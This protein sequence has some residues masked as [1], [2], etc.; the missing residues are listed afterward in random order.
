[1][2]RG[3]YPLE[4][5]GLAISRGSQVGRIRPPPRTVV[6]EA[7]RNEFARV[8]KRAS[9]A[10]LTFGGEMIPAFRRKPSTLKEYRARFACD[11]RA[12]AGDAPGSRPALGQRE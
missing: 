4:C 7:A 6:S 9:C 12:D 8:E 1:M 2:G 5:S 10:I 3:L 11:D